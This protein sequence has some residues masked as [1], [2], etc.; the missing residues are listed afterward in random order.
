MRG[1]HAGSNAFASLASA[2][3]LRISSPMLAMSPPSGSPITR[4][5]HCC[6]S[7]QWHRYSYACTSS[8][9]RFA[10]C[11]VPARDSAASP[12][13]ALL[14]M[15]CRERRSRAGRPSPC[16]LRLLTL[17]DMTDDSSEVAP[18]N[19]RRAAAKSVP[20]V[21]FFHEGVASAPPALGGRPGTDA[22]SPP[23][24]AAGASAPGAFACARICDAN[25]GGTTLGVCSPRVARRPSA[26]GRVFWSCAESALGAFDAGCTCLSDRCV[27]FSCAR[28]GAAC[29]G[30]AAVLAP[31]SG[32]RSGA[33]PDP[34]IPTV[35]WP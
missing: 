27:C 18:A 4:S 17:R 19:A 29:S 26:G 10:H 22:L 5:I 21:R 11:A 23:R 2:M 7:L 14:A 34:L 20:A 6:A 1:T 13:A 25:A 35:A 16:S 33:R 15:L 30:R 31:C 24:R 28:N 3:P 12:A 32:S 9:P 8:R